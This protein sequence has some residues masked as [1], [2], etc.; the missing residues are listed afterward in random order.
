MSLV[1]KTRMR[2]EWMDD[3]LLICYL[4]NSRVPLPGDFTVALKHLF[5][6]AS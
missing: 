3:F 2:L 4:E 5:H 6:L 1:Q